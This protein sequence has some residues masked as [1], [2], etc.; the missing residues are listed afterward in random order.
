M[1]HKN[2]KLQIYKGII[3]YLLESTNYDLKNIAELSNSS[4]EHL[5]SIYSQEMVPDDFFSE[6]GL[7]KLYLII[8]DIHPKKNRRSKYIVEIN[9]ILD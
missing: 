6:S 1:N 5:R 2:S 8:L 3:Q 9:R 7:V 4:L